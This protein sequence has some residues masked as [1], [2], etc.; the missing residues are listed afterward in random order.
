MKRK[1]R[2]SFFIFFGLLACCLWAHSQIQESGV[3]QGNVTDAEGNPLPGATVTITSPGLIGG[4]HTRLTDAKG[5]YKFPSL[6]I[7]VYRVTAELSGFSKMIREGISVHSN[8][9]LTVDFKMSQA[10]LER[11]SIKGRI[12][13]TKEDW[14][15]FTPA[16]IRGTLSGFFVGGIAGA[17]ADTYRA[18]TVAVRRCDS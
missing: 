10:A 6:M 13:L 15:R 12:W 3:I 2:A 5:F 18:G 7:G 4:A 8:L 17:G 1:V 9:S 14:K 16:C 11:L